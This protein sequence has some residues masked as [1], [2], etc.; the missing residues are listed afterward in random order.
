M[1]LLETIL[2]FIIM[3]WVIPILPFMFLLSKIDEYR[4][5]NDSPLY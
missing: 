2:L 4:H 1:R 3:I 5:R